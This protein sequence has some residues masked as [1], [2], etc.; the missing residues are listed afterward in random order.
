M[1]RIVGGS[2][3]MAL[4]LLLLALPVPSE[5]YWH[6]GYH[7][8]VPLWVGPGGGWPP[9]Y[10]SPGPPVIV[11]QPPVYESSAPVSQA[12][13]YWYYCQNPQGYYPNIQHCSTGWMQVVAPATPHGR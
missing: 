8:A 4:A 5:A 3:V 10:Y 1:K 7:V 13:V 9:Y 2:V 11:Q 6:G 12:P